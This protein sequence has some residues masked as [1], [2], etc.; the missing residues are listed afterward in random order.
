MTAG[1]DYAWGHPGGAALQAAGIQFAARYLS[2][3]Q[4]KALD[5]AEADDLAA[6]GVWSVV[7]FE[8]AAERPLSGRAAGVAD[9]QMASAQAIAAGMPDGRPIYFACDFDVTPQQQTAVN[10]YLAG[11]GSVL[12][13]GRVG[14]YGGY[15]TVSRAL[16]AG[17]AMW[18]WQTVGWSGGQ[19]DP[20]AQLRQLGSTVTIGGVDCD[21]DTAQAEDYGQWMPGRVPNPP[22]APVPAPKAVPAPD[23][24]RLDEEMR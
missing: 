7:V 18:G 3:D 22:A 13:P 14:V 17:V 2:H 15:W 12:G 20:R 5:R 9:A 19:W 21:T 11:A 24:R 1:V 6:H 4:S 16:D 10:D 23:R 8:D